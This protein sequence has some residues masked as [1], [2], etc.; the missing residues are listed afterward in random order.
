MLP[1]IPCTTDK[2]GTLPRLDADG[3]GDFQEWA[4]WTPTVE[5]NGTAVPDDSLSSGFP[6]MSLP[7]AG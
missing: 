3:Q 6:V 2:T 4:P 5:I 7:R 1:M